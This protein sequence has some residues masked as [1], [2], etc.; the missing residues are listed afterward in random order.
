MSSLTAL[1]SDIVGAAFAACDLPAE[2]GKVTVSNRPDLSQF[3][4]NGALAAAKAAKQPPRQIADRIVEKLQAQPMFRDISLA[5][6]GFINL[7]V[8]DA[9]LAEQMNRLSQ[10][11]RLGMPAKQ[12]LM[13]VL[14]YGGPNIAKPMHVGHLRAAIIGDSIRRIFA[15]VGDETVGDVHM[16]D[17]GLQMG[18]LISELE[19]RHPELP[20]FDPKNTGPFPADSP[21]TL[22]E[23]EELY[24][25]AS[26]ACKADPARLER[27]RQATAELQD[28][29]P[30]YRALW[31][32]FFDISV[33]AMKRDYGNLGVHFDL[34]KGEACVNDL[35]APM[36]EEMKAKGVVEESDGALIVRV[37]EESDKMEIPPLI[38]VKS[39]GAAMYSTTDLATI[40]DRVNCQNPDRIIYVVDHRQHLHFVQV[41]RAAIKAGLN[42][43]ASM[44]HLGYGTMNGTDGKP[45]KTRTGGVMKLDDLITM[46]SDEAKKR[47]TEHGLGSDY[48][49]EEREDIARKVGVASL[50]FADLSN[51]PI[52]NYVFDLDRFSRFEGKTGPYLLY[53]AVRIKSLLRKAEA[54]GDKPGAI[55]PTAATERDL[56][57]MLGAMPDAIIGAYEDLAP[58]RIA[59]FAY[60]LGQTFSSFYAA[61][62]IL[63]EQDEAIRRS[64]LALCALTL[65][66]FELCL[67]LLGIETPD[68]M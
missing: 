63:S 40:V 23:L 24:P 10:D 43:K 28:G 6:P 52:A 56:A 54:Q 47:L 42:G 4:C 35:I 20:Y 7:S 22:R 44:V 66:Q 41:F 19:I 33:D 27:A 48:T 60:T 57:L 34:W 39:D 32:H 11:D 1:L 53:A 38:L 13:V 25:T 31:Q 62:H 37:A 67:S 51:N 14:D 64:R 12:K 26:A 18:M 55:I 21:V 68:R 61:C 49:P 8:T 16:G 30:G 3:Q 50:K 46:V 58:N 36:V 2:Y 17:W 15:F 59:D 9:W 45:F 65:R 29:R 5:G